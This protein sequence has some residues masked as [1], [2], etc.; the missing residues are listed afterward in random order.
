MS[1]RG[2][3]SHSPE[4]GK[5]TPTVC[6][7]KAPL[8]SQI[9]TDGAMDPFLLP[10]PLPFPL[11]ADFCTPV[12]RTVSLAYASGSQYRTSSLVSK[13]IVRCCIGVSWITLCCNS[14]AW[15]TKLTSCTRC[16]CSCCG[17]TNSAFSTCDACAEFPL[18]L[19]TSAIRPIDPATD[20]VARATSSS[21]SAIY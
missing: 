1:V 20:G 7:T 16:T 14:G 6:R 5:A 9:E 18:L 19:S 11:L 2:R 4:A 8:L 3:L 12:D 21:P 10:L 13:V 17:A 15:R